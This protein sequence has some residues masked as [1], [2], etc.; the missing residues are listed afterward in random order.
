MPYDS[1]LVFHDE[2]EFQKTVSATCILAI[3]APTWLMLVRLVFYLIIGDLFKS[4]W[5]L[6][7]A[8]AAL[9]V[10]GIASSSAFCQ[11]DGFFLQC[12]I[13]AC[14]MLLTFL[15]NCMSVIC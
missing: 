10:G 12:A 8:V 14:G 9:S 3:F 2:T 7:F 15:C 6:V 4:M 13:E 1:V 11:L 5:Y